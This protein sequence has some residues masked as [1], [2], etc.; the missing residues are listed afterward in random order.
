M[1]D[2]TV[3]DT[4]TFSNHLEIEVDQIFATFGSTT[5]QRDAFYFGYNIGQ[6]IMRKQRIE[7]P[8][9]NFLENF[10]LKNGILLKRNINKFFVEKGFTTKERVHFQKGVDLGISSLSSLNDKKKH[11]P[12]M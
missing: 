7:I 12:E 8:K 1:E 6:E 4:T 9:T 3:K 11:S 2:T 5:M 10:D